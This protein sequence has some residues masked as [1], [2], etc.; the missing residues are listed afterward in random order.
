M[1]TLLWSISN[2]EAQSQGS[3][4]SAWQAEV[5]RVPGTCEYLCAA[6]PPAV[7]KPDLPGH[8]PAVTQYHL[9]LFA[10]YRDTITR[11]GALIGV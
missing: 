3:D 5:S 6:V 11:C 8:P 9:Q 4:S 7:M 2:E 10:Y 1:T